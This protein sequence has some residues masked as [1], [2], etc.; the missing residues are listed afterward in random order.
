[1]AI[2]IYNET[3]LRD[4]TLLDSYEFCSKAQGMKTA[5]ELSQDPLEAIR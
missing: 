5:N 3:S 2:V 1:M 4:D